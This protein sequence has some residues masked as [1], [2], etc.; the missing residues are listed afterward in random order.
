MPSIVGV[1]KINSVGSSA[2][3]NIGDSFYIAP[4]STSKAFAGA[5]SFTTGDFLKINNGVSST[6]IYEPHLADANIV[7]V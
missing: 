6:N 3:I 4:K 7:G 2:V 1:I 5:G